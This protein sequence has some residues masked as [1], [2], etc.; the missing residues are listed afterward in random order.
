MSGCCSSMR[1]RM[2]LLVGLPFFSP[3][4]SLPVMD[5]IPFT[6]KLMRRIVLFGKSTQKV[7]KSAVCHFRPVMA[8]QFFYVV[9]T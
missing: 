9:S 5:L 3:F 6:L 4:L 8:F 1:E 7:C 2:T